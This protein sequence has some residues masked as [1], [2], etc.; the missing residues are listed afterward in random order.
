MPLTAREVW[1]DFVVDGVPSSGAHKPGK[2]DARNWG[3]YLEGFLTS[4]GSNA[5]TVKITRALLYADLAHPAD[6]MAWVV[7]DTTIDYNGIYQKIGAS[8]VGSWTRVSDLPFSFIVATDV[9]DGTP[10]AILATTD[11][12]VSESAL[13]VFTV[14]D[15]NTASPVTVSFNGSAALTIKTNSG[16]DIAAAGLSA[17]MQVFGRIIGSTF[18]LITDQVNSAIVAAAEAAA[19]ASAGYR[20]Q[21]LGYRDA[22]A[23]YAETALEATLARGYL[24]G[25]EIS[26]NVTD[27]TNDL[28]IAAGVAASDDAAPAMMVWT[29]VTRQLDVAYGTGNGG[30]FDSA[31]ADGT[32]HIFA[33]TNGTLTAIGMSQSLVPTGAANYPSGYTKYRRIGSRVR[34]S[35]AWRRVVQRGDRH[36][37]LDPLPQTGNPIA[38]TTTAALL[39]LSGLPTGIE[40][41]ALFEA[42]FTSATVSSGA[43]LTS[44]VINDS[45]P[46]AGNAG[47]NVGHIQVTNQFTAGSLRIR[48]NTSGQVRHRAGASGNLYIA[49]HGWFDDRGSNIFKGGPS[50]GS[51]SSGGEVRSSQYNTLQE[52]INAAAGKKLVIEAGSYVT[53]G[54]TGVS[55][56]EITTGG[57]VTISTT[58]NAAILDMTGCVNWS[59][60]GHIR[61]VGNATTYTGYP[62]SLTDAGQKGIKISACDRYLI[63]G[64]IE[65]ANINGSGL[66]VELSAGSWQHDGIVKGIRATSCYHGIRYTNSGEYDHVSDFSISNCAFAVMVESGNVMFSDGKMNYNSICVSLGAGS[67]NAHGA[68]NNCQMNHSNYAV[69]AS[70]VTLGEVFNGCI[71]LGDQ[72]GA[73]HGTI[74]II[75]SVGIIWNGGQVGADISLDATS[76]MG[77]LNAYIR[78]DLTSA[79]VVVGGGV[80]TAK[81]NI[82][83]TGGLWAYNN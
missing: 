76:K 43:L 37:L 30:R 61:F 10:N 54:L 63:D 62:G 15:A 28:D 18:R 17:G 49:V 74:Q 72:A 57:P 73:G 22:A 46:G 66:F 59:L 24:F 27:L 9:G 36:L 58:T 1:R 33:C 4:V 80:F 67:N 26:N 69:S 38:T 70:G 14:F 79:P 47:I 60:K 12:P 68:F 50:T 45:S 32:W 77:L 21:A 42:S 19:T 20:D 44:P 75:N 39:A 31:I 81:N 8:G 56:I 51:S 3:T 41:D 23:A 2:A 71:A 7:Q 55:N 65:F 64:K 25:G 29:A 53:T 13:I 83:N 40:V 16:N 78:T 48:T 5:G 52:A 11:V 35:G 6:T 34:I 82:A